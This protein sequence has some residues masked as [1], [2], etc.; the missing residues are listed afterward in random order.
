MR[1]Y[2]SKRINFIE[3]DDDDVSVTDDMKCWHIVRIVETDTER[4]EDKDFELSFNEEYHSLTRQE[5]DEKIALLNET[6]DNSKPPLTKIELLEQDYKTREALKLEIQ[7]LQQRLE[8]LETWVRLKEIEYLR[9]P[10]NIT[11]TE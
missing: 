11:P 8:N 9:T 10:P 3:P 2:Y 7:R 1:A 4:Y 6:I 5:A